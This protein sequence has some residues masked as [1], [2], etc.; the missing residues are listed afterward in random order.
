MYSG[1]NPTA[2]QSRDWL[3]A[4]LI[5][6]MEEKPFSRI[7]V[8]EIC[9]RA[10]LSRQT[11]YNVFSSK[12]EI[13]QSFLRRKYEAEFARYQGNASLTIQEIVDSFAAV[14]SDNQALLSSMIENGLSWQITDAISS[15]VS[16]FAGHFVSRKRDN[17]LLPYSE[18]LL[19]GALAG[20]LTRW[21]QQ[22]EPISIDQ[23]TALLTDFFRGNLFELSQ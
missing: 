1:T 2:L 9:Q 13:L 17:A 23:M 18:A 15:C 7:T 4:A 14:L 3:T 8:K 5:D 21:F 10:D 22:E 16:L 19:S 11:F 6:L 12:E 20:L